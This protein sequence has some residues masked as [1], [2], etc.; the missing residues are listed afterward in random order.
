[1]KPLLAYFPLVGTLKTYNARQFVDDSIAAVIVTIMLIPQSL[2][3][4]LLAGLPPEMGLYASILP[5]L[6]YA[7]FGTSHALSVGP[8]AVV[9]L[10]TATALGTAQAEYGI[11]YLAGALTLAFLSGVFMLLLGVLRFGFIAN[12]LSHPVVSGFISA[13]AILI[14]LSQFKHILGI[15]ASGSTLLEMSQS[16]WRALGDTN[17]LTTV[18]GAGCLAFLWWSRKG[19]KPLLQHFRVPN[20]LLMPLVKASP[21]LAVGVTIALTA[22]LSLDKHGV[23]IIGDVP[24]GLPSLTVPVLRLEWVKALVVP[25]M[26]ISLIGYVE[27]VS[28][29]KTLAARIRQRIDPNQELIALGAANLG[30]GLSGGFPVTGG[31]SRSVVNFDAGA[32]TQIASV[33]T[34][35]G[36]LL[37]ALFLTPVLYYLP[38]VTLAA[39]IIVAVLS[40]VDSKP[41][42]HAWQYS[43]ADF[44]AI[45]ATFALTL[46]FGVEVGV[47][48]GVLASISLHLLKTATPHIAEVGLV[49][50]TEHF[51]NIE[52]HQVETSPTI[53]TLRPDESL[54][55]INANTLIERIYACVA[56]RSAIKHVI[57]Q[58][59]AVNAIDLSALEA[60]EALNE[61]LSSNG[62]K[63]HFSEIKG[64]VMDKLQKSGFLA[65]LSGEVFLTQFSAYRLLKSNPKIGV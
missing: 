9:S 20:A 60:L 19:L 7:I 43:K 6:L 55:F 45:F 12:L 11:D 58:C 28:V 37:A 56:E 8:V 14:A 31:F 41:F 23:N 15:R 18:I 64:P 40:L 34:A 33:L 32:A 30:A 10:M 46:L 51:R 35:I 63:L 61:Q 24:N 2:A 44:A 27:S 65:H 29:G 25:A 1:M 16:Q 50:D 42:V 5:L 26:L 21:V 17:L 22:G 38:K 59:N 4:A 54:Y 48:S 62:I 3:Y 52:R 53:L 49:P 39:T 57:I 47:L 13:S 36:I